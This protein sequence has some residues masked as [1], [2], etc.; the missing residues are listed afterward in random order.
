MPRVRGIHGLT[1]ITIMENEQ[2]R[3]YDPVM[4]WIDRIGNM[5]FTDDQSSGTFAPAFYW[6][7]IRISDK[8]GFNFNALI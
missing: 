2:F 3:N 6:H 5:E 1:W 7:M 4:F 8:T